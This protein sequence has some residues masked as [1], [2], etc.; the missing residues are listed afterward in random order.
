MIDLKHLREHPDALQEAAKAKNVDINISRVLELDTKVRALQTDLE[1]ISARKN[2]ASK[3]I[4]HAPDNEREVLINQ[5]REVDKQAHTLKE[6]LA[7]A[8]EELEELLY[9]IPNPALEDVTVSPNEED[10]AVIK[11]VGEKPV[12]DFEPKNHEMLAVNLGILD[13]EQ[14]AKASGS[15]FAYIKGN[16]ALLQL[17]LIQ[18]ALTTVAKHGFSPIIVP[19]LVNADSMRAMGYLEHGGHDEIYYLP[20][21]N[22]YLIGTSEQSIGPMHKD[23][24]L[25]REDLPARYA[26]ISS[27]Y[28]RE[29]G[30]YGKDTGGIIRMHQFDKIE[31]FSVTSPEASEAEHKLL[32]ALE[33]ELMQG[34]QIPYQVVKMVTGDLG[35]PAA[36]KYDIEAWMPTQETYRETHSTSTT[37]DFQARRLNTRYKTKEGK[38]AFVHMLNGTAFAVGRTLAVILENYQEADGSVRIPEVLQPFM[39]GITKLEPK[40]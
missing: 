25:K 15:R 32:L 4:A 11:T 9:R 3:A 12:F 38:N 31:L 34:L 27:C 26:G 22:L 18:Y 14:A 17:A 6:Q 2:E 8:Q 28:R 35:L 37:T 10:N 5:M 36:R 29:A 30:S 33:E 24:I 16:G 21:D 23:V 19:H 20:K 7:P 13:K 40:A 39:G 1:A